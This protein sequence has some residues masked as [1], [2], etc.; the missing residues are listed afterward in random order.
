M[1]RPELRAIAV[2]GEES[3]LPVKSKHRYEK[4]YQ[5]FKAWCADKNVH[6]SGS[7]AVLLAYFNEM[8]QSKQSLTLWSTYSMLRTTLNIK[9]GVDISKFGKVLA[10][11]N[12]QN[13]GYKAKKSSTFTIENIEEFLQ[14]GSKSFLVQKVGN[15]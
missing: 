6:K 4:A 2:K 3:L 14:M 5:S 12:R 1:K 13:I 15:P 11:W 10:F 8:G 9:E 7:E